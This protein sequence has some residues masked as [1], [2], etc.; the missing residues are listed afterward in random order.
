MNQSDFAT[1]V[2]MTPRI[3]DQE[4]VLPLISMIMVVMS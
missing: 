2:P 3:A 1:E 4:L